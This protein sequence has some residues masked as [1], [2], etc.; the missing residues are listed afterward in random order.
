MMGHAVTVNITVALALI[1][2]ESD[3]GLSDRLI[4]VLYYLSVL[5]QKKE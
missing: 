2:G 4:E 5:L 3:S 1:M